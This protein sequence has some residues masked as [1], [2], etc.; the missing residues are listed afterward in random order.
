MNS[1]SIKKT[2]VRK[3]GIIALSFFGG[4]SAIGFW[5]AKPLPATFFGILS[6]LGCGL[7][8][9]PKKLTCIYEI[10]IKF[11]HYLGKAFTVLMLTF[12]YFL[13]IT[14]SAFLKRLISGPPIPLKSDPNK[15]SYWVTRTESAQPKE[16]FLKRY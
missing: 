12:A 5:L 7:V 3:F 16:R 6:M 10:W 8:L 1:N 15:T 14:P 11:A 2:E 13:V 4:L 9:L